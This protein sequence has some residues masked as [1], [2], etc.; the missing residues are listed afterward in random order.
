MSLEHLGIQQK[1]V[2]DVNV[3]LFR[4]YKFYFQTFFERWIF[5]E[6]QVCNLI[7]VVYDYCIRTIASAINSHQGQWRMQNSKK[8]IWKTRVFNAAHLRNL[9]IAF[10]T[11]YGRRPAHSCW[12]SR[13][14]NSERSP[15][16]DAAAHARLRAK[17]PLS[18][19]SPR[20]GADPP[21]SPLAGRPTLRVYLSYS[22]WLSEHRPAH[23]GHRCSLLRPGEHIQ[24]C[25]HSWSW[26]GGIGKYWCLMLRSSKWS[27][28]YR[29]FER[30]RTECWS[31]YLDLRGRKWR[32]DG[33]VW[34]VI[35][36]TNSVLH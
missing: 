12:Q 28:V 7:R 3:D 16:K 5:N 33:K 34:T 24:H 17:L 1:L 22:R 32:E 14:R 15:A 30:L 11:G 31:E 13:E 21:T 8:G 29:R 6:L 10:R 20:I 25:P 26:S 18:V 35:N 36:F 4:I 27:F 9:A 19:P 2:H 23:A